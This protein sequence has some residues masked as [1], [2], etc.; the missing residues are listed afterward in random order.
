MTGPA[1]WLARLRPLRV[2]LIAAMF[3]LPLTQVLSVALVAFSAILGGLRVAMQDATLALLLLLGLA[4]LGGGGWQQF[5]IAALLS[6][7]ATALAGSLVGR[8]GTLNLPVQL[9]TGVALALVA[10]LGLLAGDGS[11]TWLPLLEAWARQLTEAGVQVD[12]GLALQELARLMN[13][14]VA[15]GLLLLLL[16]GLFLGAALAAAAGGPPF[17]MMFRELALGRVFAMVGLLAALGAALGLTFAA[18]LL[19]VLLFAFFLQGLAVVHW[20]ANSRQWPGFWP[21]ALYGPLLLLAPL[22]AV[23]ILSL[24]SIGFLDNWTQLRRARNDVV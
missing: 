1:S 22:A 24:G 9:L 10:L 21:L 18:H 2:T 8:Y 12:E 20:F 7:P 17:G 14:L 11:T 13:G 3:L 5:T 4:M 23:I 16:L 15:A 6:W 19:L